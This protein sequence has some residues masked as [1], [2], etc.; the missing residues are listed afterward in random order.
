MVIEAKKVK[1]MGGFNILD[2][3]IS[4]FNDK[5]NGEKI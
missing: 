1:Q 2:C 4:R 3:H 5:D